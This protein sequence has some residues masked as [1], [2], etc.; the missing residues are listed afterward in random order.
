MCIEITLD[1]HLINIKKNNK[2]YTIN[3]RKIYPIYFTFQ[4]YFLL[5]RI[6]IYWY[7][8][9]KFY[10]RTKLKLVEK[11]YLDLNHTKRWLLNENMYLNKVLTIICNRYGV[12]NCVQMYNLNDL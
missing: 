11:K 10:L 12:D 3:K 8:V 4:I 6:T 1:H 5:D 9:N 2:N 7:L